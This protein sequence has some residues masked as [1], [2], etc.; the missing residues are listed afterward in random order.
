MPDASKNLRR[1]PIVCLSKVSG[2]TSS[3]ASKVGEGRR[4]LDFGSW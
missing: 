3:K 4:Q 1:Q 2:N